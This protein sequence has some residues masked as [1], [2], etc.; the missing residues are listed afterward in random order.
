MQK[1]YVRLDGGRL[2]PA[3][4]K[5]LKTGG[6]LINNY[7]AE[8]N[9]PMLLADGY[10]TIS[11]TDYENYLQGRMELQEDG[12]LKD[13]TTSD[14]YIN[15]QKLVAKKALIL[16]YKDY[17]NELDRT[18]AVKFARGLSTTQ[19]VEAERTV[20]QTELVTKLSEV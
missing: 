12:T 5:L 1:I 10:H 20:L 2:T 6:I 14:E 3:P 15:A 8:S 16:E 4:K 17:F 7:N 18:S 9:L 19:E 13:I 11:R